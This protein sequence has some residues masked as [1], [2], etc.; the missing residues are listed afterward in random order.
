[1][2]DPGMALSYDA[3]MP[4][5]PLTRLSSATTEDENENENETETENPNREEDDRRDSMVAMADDA[6]VHPVPCMQGPFEESMVEM[7]RGHRQ[8]SARASSRDLDAAAR[9][10]KLFELDSHQAVNASKAKGSMPVGQFHPLWKQVAQLSFGIHLLHQ[11]LSKSDEEVIDVLQTHVDG[12]DRFLAATT[13]DFELALQDVRGRIEYLRLPLEHADVFDTM[14]DDRKFRNSIVEGN[15]N[16][17]HI[18]NRTAAAMDNAL[19]DV[20]KGLAAATEFAN[21]LRSLDGTWEHASEELLS[22]YTAMRGNAHGWC[23]AFVAL[24]KKGNKLGVAL[25][26]LGSIVG[27]MQRRAGI[28]SRRHRPSSRP[29]TSQDMAKSTPARSTP[30]SS[31]RNSIR[32]PSNLQTPKDRLSPAHLEVPKPRLVQIPEQRQQS[33]QQKRSSSKSP[34]PQPSQTERKPA[35]QRSHSPQPAASTTQRDPPTKKLRPKP[36][37]PLKIPP[38]QAP[39]ITLAHSRHSSTSTIQ[40]KPHQGLS[41]HRQSQSHPNLRGDKSLPRSPIEP[42]SPFS[43]P[44]DFNSNNSNN[45]NSRSDS[46]Y[47]STFSSEKIV[48]TPPDMFPGSPLGSPGPPRSGAHSML[49]GSPLASSTASGTD[50]GKRGSITALPKPGSAGAGGDGT[51]GKRAGHT[52]KKLSLESLKSLFHKRHPSS[53]KNPLSTCTTIS[54]KGGS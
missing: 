21:Y 31:A 14:L 35:K 17:E 25:I 23:K 20:Q 49:K 54:E 38:Y 30:A 19:K 39:E 10:R 53:S 52:R 16:I 34:S 45:N 28:A 46:A 44:P 24:Q 40:N 8:R 13:E 47:A 36:R 22:V 2:R 12:I 15:E 41:S 1:M 11:H 6:P 7:A 37:Q 18:I 42:L 27:E 3:P 9:R 51:G 26:Q 5:E 33:R 32:A 43:R 29:P 4:H 48:V 50:G